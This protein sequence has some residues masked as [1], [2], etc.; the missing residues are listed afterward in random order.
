MV[1]Q[2]SVCKPSNNV[3]PNILPPLDNDATCADASDNHSDHHK[4]ELTSPN[5]SNDIIKAEE[6]S[7]DDEGCHEVHD[8]PLPLGYDNTLS[9]TIRTLLRVASDTYD[10]YQDTLDDTSDYSSLTFSQA[11]TDTLSKEW[12]YQ[13]NDKKTEDDND[14]ECMT[15]PCNS[16]DSTVACGNKQRSKTGTGFGSEITID[17][18]DVED[19]HHLEVN[20]ETPTREGKS[21]PSAYPPPPSSITSP[22]KSSTSPPSISILVP[23]FTIVK[24]ELHE[25]DSQSEG[26]SNSSLTISDEE[27][28]YGILEG[29]QEV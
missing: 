1:R 23:T 17:T 15:P 2:L 29:R 9:K 13:H 4:P 18:T 6:E 11:T 10:E 24:D 12:I 7:K 28:Q 22:E 8:L 25:F 19:S 3:P 27:S 5:S 14:L 20:D 26:S 16:D 21:S